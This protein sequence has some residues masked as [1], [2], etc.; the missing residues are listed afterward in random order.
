LSRFSGFKKEDKS[1][2]PS[3]PILPEKHWS[4]MV[5]NVLI[6]PEWPEHIAHYLTHDTWPDEVN[7]EDLM[8]KVKDFEIRNDKLYRKT[9]FG[10][11][12]YVPKGQRLQ[13]L[14]RFH[15]GIGHLAS[16]SVQHLLLRRFWWPDMK[17][18]LSHY[19]SRCPKCQLNKNPAKNDRDAQVVPLRPIPPVALPFERVGIDF[20][21]NLQPTKSGNQHII[22]LIDYATRWVVA[23]A[24]PR[25]N[26]DTVVKFLYEDILMNYGCPFEIISDRGS[27]FMSETMEQFKEL[28]DIKHLASTPYHP[29]TNGM[30]ERMHSMLGHAITTLSDSHPDRWDEYLPQAIF[31]LRV[32]THAVTKFSPFYLLYGVH[33]RLPGDTEPPRQT[34]VPLDELE[35]REIRMEFMA[36]ELDELGQSRAAAYNRSLLQAERMQKLHNL[37]DDAKDHFFDV[38][39]MV[40]LKHFTKEKF[41]FKWRGP[42]HVVKLAFPGT[43]WIMDANGRWL[44]STINQRDLAPWLAATEE[45]RDYFYDG[46]TRVVSEP[47]PDPRA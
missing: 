4:K 25:M 14:R 41:E 5:L 30:V 3:D 44:N 15:D 37:S 13:V 19:I 42:Y 17:Q 24:V 12:L 45:N 32:R 8:P 6:T 33:P 11:A 39:D 23:R 18:N 27:A 34:M 28:Q 31:A 38:G 35:Q 20:I 10:Y 7:P 40:K 22:T 43:Y 1:R 29:Q 47:A 2:S 21:Q 36:R 16:G 26:A 9:E 46:T